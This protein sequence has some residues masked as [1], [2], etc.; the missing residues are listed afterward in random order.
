MGYEA[1]EAYPIKLHQDHCYD[2]GRYDSRYHQ[3]HAP[4]LPLHSE[5]DTV[6]IHVHFEQQSSGFTRYRVWVYKDLLACAELGAARVSIRLFT[7]HEDETGPLF[8]FRGL[9]RNPLVA[10]TLGPERLREAH[11][12]D[13]SALRVARL[14]P[15]LSHL[16]LRLLDHRPLR[17]GAELYLAFLVKID[18]LYCF[19]CSLTSSQ[20]CGYYVKLFRAD[21]I[22][23]HPTADCTL[24]YT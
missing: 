3:L 20:L 6:D 1:I 24:K 4:E 15:D 10:H 13:E 22:F 16:G 17:R 9:R 11:S 5:T 18:S 12:T 2:R 19:D 21:K 14:Y 23:L 8:H 7:A